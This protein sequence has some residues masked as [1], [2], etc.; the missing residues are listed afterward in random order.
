VRLGG[1]GFDLGV[2]WHEDERGAED[3]AEEVR[4]Q[5][6]RAEVRRLDLADL[7]GAADVIDELADALGGID[8]L[9][10]NSGTSRKGGMLE[11]SYNDWRHTLAV[12]LDGA[13]LCAQRAALRMV[14]RAA[15][16]ASSTSRP[17]TNTR[18]SRPAAPTRSRSTGSAG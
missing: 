9:V 17:S 13:F 12:D 2:T 10:N 8:L 6:R 15:A 18:H 7:P 3:T 11:L 5:G 14:K 4:R 1:D 16:G